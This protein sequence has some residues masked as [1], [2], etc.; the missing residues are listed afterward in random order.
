MRRRKATVE[1]FEA[2]RREY[3]FGIGTI[4]GVARKFGVHRRMVR[5]ALTGPIPAKSPPAP[6]P[7]PRLDPVA[8]FI[9]AILEVDRR[10]P[11]KQRHTAHRIYVR[12]QHERPN[13]PV[14]E[15]TVRRYVRSRKLALGLLSRETF[16]PQSYPWGSE[17]QVDWY[18]AAADLDGV[19]VTVQVFVIRSMASGAAFHRAYQRPTQQAFLE[20]HQLA[21]HYFGGVFHRLRYDNLPLAVKRILRGFQREET[22]RFIAFRSHWRF[23]AEF[24]NPAEAHEKGGV[25]GEVGTFRRN[26]L[27]PVP[28]ARDLADLNEYL[29]RGCREDEGRILEGRER[30][31]GAA[32]LIERDHLLPLAAE[33]FDLAE[34]CFPTVN[35]LGCVKVRTNAYSVPVRPGTTVETKITPT[36]I[37]IHHEGKR[38]AVHQRCY[39]RHQEILDLEHY[40]DVL[41]HKPGAFAGS[42]PLEQWRTQGRWPQSYDQFWEG[43]IARQG[44]H[45]GTKE[46]IGLLLLGRTHGQEK[47]RTA[48]EMA[49]QLGCQ[50]S[51]AVRHLLISA[52]LHK[53]PTEPLEAEALLGFN[54]PLPSLG[55]YDQLLTKRGH[56]GVCSPLPSPSLSTVGS[57]R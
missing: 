22:T 20:A 53:A 43:L 39:G 17:A 46:M 41:A 6:R 28:Q 29:L 5:E 9:D 23:Q 24:T 25:E 56:K 52:S 19:R 42:K 57:A 13:C 4:Q 12:L 51:A 26:H 55:E 3:E 11:R 27:V 33:D 54:R 44:K 37:E 45:A 36:T 35:D 1:L 49:L 31:V 40:L 47:L 38:V 10:A 34:T 8:T 18:E 21:F 32:M 48:I 30:S 14:A 7:R 16:V 50:D 15:S 2:I